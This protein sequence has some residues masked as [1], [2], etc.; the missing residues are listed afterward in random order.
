[1]CILVLLYDETFFH[2]KEP[3][4]LFGEEWKKNVCEYEIVRVSSKKIAAAYKSRAARYHFCGHTDRDP[5][6][7]RS[8][9]N[10]VNL[11]FSELL[12]SFFFFSFYNFFII[13]TLCLLSPFFFSYNVSITSLFLTKSS[14]FSFEKSLITIFKSYWKLER[15]VSE[16]IDLKNLLKSFLIK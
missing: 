11:E 7:P 14:L 2:R 6:N 9:F 8:Q 4:V 15:F 1:M 3:F 13:Y 16:K 5:T 10:S 12:T